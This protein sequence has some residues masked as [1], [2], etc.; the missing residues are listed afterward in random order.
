MSL[1]VSLPYCHQTYISTPNFESIRSLEVGEIHLTRFDDTQANKL[2]KIGTGE[3][4][5]K[6]KGS[7]SL[8]VAAKK[9]D[10]Q[11]VSRKKYRYR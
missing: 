4:K 11:D 8:R 10:E 1:S 5:N 6:R 7:V 3:A 9:I 2:T